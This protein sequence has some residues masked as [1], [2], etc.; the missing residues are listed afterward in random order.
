MRYFAIFLAG[1]LLW[2]MAAL[3]DSLPSH[4]A[5]DQAAEHFM[6]LAD[7]GKLGDAYA[8][9]RNYLGVDAAAYE[10]SGKKA[11]AYFKQVFQNAGSPIG[12]VLVDRQAIGHQ[13]YRVTMLQKYG[14]A[15]IAWQFTFY[16]PK[17]GWLLVDISSST[18][19][20]DLFRPVEK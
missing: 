13:L 11:E 3:A 20:N 16:Q 15:A 9:F 12:A 10:K 14:S 1:L 2:P 4:Q 5:A 17:Q 8:Y 19:I 7:Q 18:N 6:E